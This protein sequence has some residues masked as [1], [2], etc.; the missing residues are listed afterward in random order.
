[1]PSGTSVVSQRIAAPRPPAD[2]YSSRRRQ[3][4]D[5]D[6]IRRF[7]G[8]GTAG[9]VL[10]ANVS[11][12]F[13]GALPGWIQY[14][15]YI[16]VPPP[17][18]YDGDDAVLTFRVNGF[19]LPRVGESLEFDGPGNGLSLTVTEVEHCFSIAE[20]TEHPHHKLVV[21]AEI[22]SPLQVRTAQELFEDHTKLQQWIDQFPMV[23]PYRFRRPG[24][25]C[26]ECADA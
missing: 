7:G 20:D 6:R 22:T 25:K 5:F 21:A 24:V 15:V 8:Q 17:P 13:E 16:D 12:A 18:G 26:T 1:M 19:A 9:E 3:P 4:G 23:R 14:T 11:H 10:S 2:G